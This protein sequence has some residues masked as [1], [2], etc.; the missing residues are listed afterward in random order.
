[1]KKENKK[2]LRYY[3]VVKNGIT[4][5]QKLESDESFTESEGEQ[6]LL[7]SDKDIKSILCICNSKAEGFLHLHKL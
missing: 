1:M 4:S 2:C 7:E 6:F 5:Y 3:L